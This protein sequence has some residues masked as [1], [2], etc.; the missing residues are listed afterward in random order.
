MKRK[1]EKKL[2]NKQKIEKL[3]GEKEKKNVEQYS[4]YSK[5]WRS[6][7]QRKKAMER[8][9]ERWMQNIMKDNLKYSRDKTR[10]RSRSRER[11]RSTSRGREG[12]SSRRRSI[13]RERSRYS[14]RDEDSTRGRRRHSRERSPAE[15]FSLSS[16]LKAELSHKEQVKREAERMKKE[17]LVMGVN[18][19]KNLLEKRDS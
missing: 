3:G 8:E 14:R 19:L 16:I 2:K 10:S 13:S 18:A 6:E 11:R 17:A 5:R 4:M 7:G 15:N 1:M 9:E 12:R